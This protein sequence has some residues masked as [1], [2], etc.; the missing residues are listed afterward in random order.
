MSEQHPTAVDR[1]QQRA[2]IA[3][4]V[5]FGL[6]HP[7]MTLED[8]LRDLTERADGLLSD[9]EREAL[10]AMSPAAMRHAVSV[11]WTVA[12]EHATARVMVKHV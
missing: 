6:Y 2:A 5:G 8:A 7:A 9:V 10:L 12:A 11:G 3:W 4:G 1:V